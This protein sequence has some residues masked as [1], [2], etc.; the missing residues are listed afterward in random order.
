MSF[1]KC[2]RSPPS[3]N[4]NEQKFEKASFPIK[5]E[6]CGGETI[7]EGR[8]EHLGSFKDET[9][10]DVKK[11]ECTI[12]GHIAQDEMCRDETYEAYHASTDTF[13]GFVHKTFEKRQVPVSRLRVQ[14]KSAKC[15]DHSPAVSKSFLTNLKVFDARR[16][17]TCQYYNKG[18]RLKKFKAGEPSPSLHLANHTTKSL[19]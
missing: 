5:D 3:K 10:G 9:Y 2:F 16:L 15:R 14:R 18:E 19:F 7:K 13:P 12:R 6:I 17:R 11:L 1:T 8:F 4:V